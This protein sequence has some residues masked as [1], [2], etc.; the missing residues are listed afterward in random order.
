M[1][2]YDADFVAKI[3]DY[4]VGNIADFPVIG[5]NKFSVPITAKSWP[6]YYYGWGVWFNQSQD[7]IDDV[8]TAA[9]MTNRGHLANLSQSSG[10]FRNVVWRNAYWSSKRQPMTS[11]TL[12]YSNSFLDASG[13]HDGLNTIF[14]TAAIE[15]NN[16][17]YPVSFGATRECTIAP[18]GIA[19]SDPVTVSIP[20]DTMFWVRQ[21]VRTA[22][23]TEKYPTGYV[24]LASLGEGYSTTTPLAQVDALG[25]LTGVLQSNMFGPVAVLGTS[26][27]T[28]PPHVAIFGS[29]SAFGTGENF[30]ALGVRGDRG[31]LQRLVSNN[32]GQ[33]VMATA[34]DNLGQWLS[35]SSR[36]MAILAATRPSHVVN[37]LGSNDILNSASAA[38]VQSRLQTLWDQLAAAGYRV[39]QTTFSPSSTGSWA[40]LAG[41][42]P[43]F[44]ATRAQVNAFI[45]TVPPPLVGVLD[46]MAITESSPGS[47]LWRIDGGPWTADGTHTIRHADIAAALSTSVFG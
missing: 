33:V 15:Y 47:G 19:K 45:R 30:A 41:Q 28:A 8:S 46:V 1:P 18:G 31:Y 34:G 12:V 7:P 40:T 37:Q 35:A 42:T 24:S 17:H 4:R 9:I 2:V 27:E 21:N 32:F 22:N 25:A 13:E 10:S 11:V 39:L 5:A 43:T 23:A 3:L 29:S 16:G 20:P 26:I 36:R 6:D 38:T 14:V 44:T